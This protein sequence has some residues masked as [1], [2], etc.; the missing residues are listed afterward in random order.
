[1]VAQ[2]VSKKIQDVT[3]YISQNTECYSYNPDDDSLNDHYKLHVNKTANAVVV[4][5]FRDNQRSL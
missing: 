4:T 3:S 1:M 5:L 2:R